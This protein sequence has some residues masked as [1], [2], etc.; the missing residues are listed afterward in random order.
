MKTRC[1]PEWLLPPWGI[2]IW[3][4]Q[5]VS[6][7]PTASLS[8]TSALKTSPDPCSGTVLCGIL[9]FSRRP[10]DF[11]RD[12]GDFSSSPDFGSSAP[13]GDAGCGEADPS[14]LGEGRR[15][16][17]LRER[18]GGLAG[19]EDGRFTGE[20]GGAGAGGAGGRLGRPPP[21]RGGEPRFLDPERAAA[22]LL[23][24][25]VFWWF[26]FMYGRGGTGFRG[27]GERCLERCGRRLDGERLLRDLDNGRRLEPER[28]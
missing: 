16:E 17:R 21:P 5:T 27:S 6:L 4:C 25:N 28:C 8:T 10:S 20:S 7:P 24:R 26:L 19:G 13:A 18:R 22:P 2:V 1:R 11:E 15:C 23:L 12:L 9:A 3:A 14:G